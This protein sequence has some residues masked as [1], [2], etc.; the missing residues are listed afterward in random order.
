MMLIVFYLFPSSFSI[1]SPSIVN[2]TAACS[3]TFIRPHDI[4][5]FELLEVLVRLDECIAYIAERTQTMD[6]PN[7]T[8][9]L[10]AADLATPR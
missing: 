5:A 9:S 10:L 3:A 2:V 8:D 1:S 7:Y 6:E 4:V